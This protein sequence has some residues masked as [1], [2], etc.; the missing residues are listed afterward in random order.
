MARD[1][2]TTS[3]WRPGC[4]RGLSPGQLRDGERFEDADSLGD[5]EQRAAHHVLLLL[6]RRDQRRRL[7]QHTQQRL[8]VAGAK[9]AAQQLE[10]VEGRLPVDGLLRLLLLSRR[11]AGTPAGDLQ[12]VVGELHDFADLKGGDAVSQTL[13]E[14]GKSDVAG[15]AANLLGAPLRAVLQLV[16]QQL[17]GLPA[18]GGQLVSHQALHHRDEGV[19]G[20]QGVDLARADSHR[21]RRVRQPEPEAEEVLI[22]DTVIKEVFKKYFLGRYI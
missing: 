7:L 5:A 12:E 9:A 14:A 18:H 1:I 21:C 15:A 17:H 19:G 2:S 11:C 16:V 8:L 10:A 4:F 3:R 13:G 20:Q 22:F 6:R